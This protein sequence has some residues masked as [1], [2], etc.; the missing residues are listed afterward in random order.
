MLEEKERKNIDTLYKLITNRHITG[1]YIPPQMFTV[2]RELYG[3]LPLKYVSVAG[4]KFKDKY[5][6]CR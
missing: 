6:L 5:P 4:E 2:M 3:R 1:I